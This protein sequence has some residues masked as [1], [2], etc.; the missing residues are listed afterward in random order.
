MRHLSLIL[1]IIITLGCKSKD[2]TLIK[3]E[4]IQE[5]VAIFEDIKKI[6]F[7]HSVLIPDYDIKDLRID[8]I[9]QTEDD[10]PCDSD[11]VDYHSVGFYLG[12]GLYIDFND[13]ISLL[14]PELLE[15]DD[16][17]N[18]VLKKT[19][20]GLFQIIPLLIKVLILNSSLKVMDYLI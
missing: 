2:L 9:R 17:K 14:V 3:S 19:K 8:I 7:E 12:N 13:N 20:S 6:N 10:G 16:N 5:Q 15:F 18:F 4:Q 11:D 1:V